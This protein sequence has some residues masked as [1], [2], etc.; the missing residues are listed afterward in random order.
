MAEAKNNGNGRKKTI[1]IVVLIAAVALGLTSVRIMSHPSGIS[2]RAG[3]ATRQ[4]L[5]TSVTTNAKVE[6]LQKYEAH[7]PGPLTVK[8]VYVQAGDRVEAGKLL[9]QLDDAAAR[10][11]VAKAQADLLAAQAEA[12]C[13]QNGGC[14]SEQ[15]SNTTELNRAQNE[16][17]TAKNNLATVQKLH[18]Q[19]AAT[20]AELQAAQNR[21]KLAQQQVDAIGSRKNNRYSGLDKSKAD[22]LVTQAQAA[23]HEAQNLLDQTN[24]RAPFAGTVYF[25]G[26]KQSEFVN[27][28]DLLLQLADLSKLQVRA[29]IDEPEIGHLSV[30]DPVSVVWDALPNRT[31]SGSLTQVPSSITTYGTRNVGQALSQIEN[32]DSRLIPNVNV[33]VTIITSHESGVIA[34]PRE[35]LH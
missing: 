6:P 19:E 4:D 25:V 29:Y 5:V 21:V 20:D 32:P 7:S 13:V 14:T 2:V 12:S 11:Q 31:W 22:A 23:L 1:G 3:R 28:G 8:K 18:D 16:L 30:G 24:I 10:E 35:A 26:P 15:F 33:T 27:S 9:M 34:V 17:A